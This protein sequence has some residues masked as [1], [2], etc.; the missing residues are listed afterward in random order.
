VES[1]RREQWKLLGCEI[2]R[3]KE[4]STL[5]LNLGTQRLKKAYASENLGVVMVMV[6]NTRILLH[7]SFGDVEPTVGNT[8]TLRTVA[9]GNTHKF[10]L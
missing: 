6:M 10:S 9:L 7:E 2:D 5:N 1:W 3:D 4:E 8:T